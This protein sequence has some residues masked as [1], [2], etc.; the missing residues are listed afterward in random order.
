MNRVINIPEL[1]DPDRL[2]FLNMTVLKLNSCKIFEYIITHRLQ[3]IN[4]VQNKRPKWNSNVG[5]I[6]LF[7]VQLTSKYAVTIKLQNEK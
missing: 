1:K 4:Y 7:V 2:I 6:L 3:A 5:G